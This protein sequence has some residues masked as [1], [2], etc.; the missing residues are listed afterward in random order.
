[1]NV[2]FLTMS[3]IK[4][5]NCHGIYEDL[6]REFVQNG[7]RVYIVAPNEKRYGESTALKEENGCKILRVRTGNLQK[8]NLIEKGIS[9]LKITGQFKRAIRKYFKG[10]KFDLVL[11]STPPITLVKVVNYIKKRDN[12]FTFLLLKDIFPQNAVDLGIL[13]TRGLKG[14]IYKYFRK[15]EKKLYRISDKI[16]CMSQANADY[17]LQ[18]NKQVERGKLTIVPNSIEPQDLTLNPEEKVAMRNKYGLPLDKKVFV[19]GGNLGR[20]QGVPFLIDC[21]RSQANNESAFFFIVGDGTEYGKL[22]KFIEEDK[23]ENVKLM[24]SLPREDFD[25]ML[26][27][28][29]V[30]MIFLDFRFTIPNYPS[31]ILS[32]MQAGLPVLA[33]TDINTDIGKDITDN[34]FGWWCGSDKVQGFGEC[35]EKIIEDSGNL[36]DYGKNSKEYLMQHF[37]VNKVYERLIDDVREIV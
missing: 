4:T 28:C 9:T 13:R 30:G 27:A 17:V 36:K 25:A 31:R 37:T 34:G 3:N 29:D 24:R 19:Y 18:H 7:H 10:V 21:L 35:I 5:L 8:T 33:C 11:Y 32:Y 2:I 1:M 15:Q 14:I 6:M 26:A 16:G 20:P 23:P 12:A 22:E